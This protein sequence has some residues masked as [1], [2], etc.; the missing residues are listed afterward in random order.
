MWDPLDTYFLKA[1][2]RELAKTTAYFHYTK[3]QNQ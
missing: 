1:T 3:L 2:G